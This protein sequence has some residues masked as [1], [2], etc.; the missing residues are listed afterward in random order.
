MANPRL[1]SASSFLLVAPD[2]LWGR[3][4]LKLTCDPV[5]SD[6]WMCV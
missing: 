6:A 3:D 5:C 4:A 1:V 2:A